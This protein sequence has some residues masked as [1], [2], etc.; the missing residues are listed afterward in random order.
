MITQNE[1]LIKK[2]K[3]KIQKEKK[4]GMKQRAKL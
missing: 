4:R 1:C 3:G 2:K